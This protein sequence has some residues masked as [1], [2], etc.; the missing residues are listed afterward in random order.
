MFQVDDKGLERMCLRQAQLSD[1]NML[2]D[3]FNGRATFDQ[4][5]DCIGIHSHHEVMR[6]TRTALPAHNILMMAA[7]EGRV[8][9]CVAP[10][11]HRTDKGPTCAVRG[12]A[13]I[14]VQ[15][16]KPWQLTGGLVRL[17]L[18]FTLAVHSALDNYLQAGQMPPPWSSTRIVPTVQPDQ[19]SNVKDGVS[20]GRFPASY[21]YLQISYHTVCGEP[22]F[23]S[24]VNLNIY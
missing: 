7:P 8:C 14:A 17:K 13:I 12:A 23:G 22:L 18:T 9:G 1:T 20:L 24:G 2:M 6:Q 4:A 21:L 11:P 15:L 16:Q 3:E 10:L 19:T 5:P